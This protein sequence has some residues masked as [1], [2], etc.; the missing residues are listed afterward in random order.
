MARRDPPIRVTPARSTRLARRGALRVALTALFAAGAAF[1]VGWQL[2]NAG[3][4]AGSNARLEAR[5]AALDEALDAER[6]ARS[7]LEQELAALR[8]FAESLPATPPAEARAA[9]AEAT[10]SPE[11]TPAPPGA[12]AGAV[13]TAKLFDA[14]ALLAGCMD[15]RDVERLRARWE[16]YEL[17]RLALN[18]SARRE[19]F[20]MTPRHRD[21][22][23]A[24]DA[25]FREEIGEDGFDA[26]LRAT[27]KPNRVAVKALL[28]SGAGRSA[29]LEIG[30]ELV[31]YAGARVFA[32]GELQQL[33]A[34][35]RLGEL[36]AIEVM[37]GGQPLTL[38]APRGPLGIVLEPVRRAPQGGC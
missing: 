9:G 37:R 30:D 29:G 11:P 17:D 36:I 34:S 18:D 8:T 1:G 15:R 24:L 19:G 3:G 25:A 12:E 28:P 4:N 6:T 26:Y 32:P 14:E 20:F 2:R 35:G 13:E 16:R 23:F 5:L 10:A 22:H 27:G 31:E 38:R 21:E 33:T 7:A